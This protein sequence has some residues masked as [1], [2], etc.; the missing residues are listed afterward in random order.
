MD[1]IS[2]YR[3]ESSSNSDIGGYFQRAGSLGHIALMVV[4]YTIL[5]TVLWLTW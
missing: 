1:K 4:F 3:L 2:S 5:F